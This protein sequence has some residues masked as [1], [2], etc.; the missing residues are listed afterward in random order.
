MCTVMIQC[1]VIIALVQE[2]A[3]ALVQCRAIFAP[4]ALLGALAWPKLSGNLVFVHQLR[5]PK[6]QAFYQDVNETRPGN[7]TYRVNK[8]SVGKK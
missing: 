2:I 3:V 8:V 1:K 6:Y 7:R 4:C 5:A